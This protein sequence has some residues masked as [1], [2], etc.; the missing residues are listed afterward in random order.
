MEKPWGGRFSEE[1]DKFVEEFTES[2]SFDRELAF[3]DLRQSKAHV[4]TLLRAGVITEEEARRLLDGLDSIERDILEGSFKFSTS[5][6]DVHMNIEAELTKRV[7]DVGG[8]LHTGRSRNDQVATDERL[9]L[10][11]VTDEILDLLSQLR[12][13]LIKKAKD[14]LNLTMP[15]YTHLQRAQ[16]IRVAHYFLAYREMFL[17]DSER[18]CDLLRRLDE[19]PLGS[20]SVAGV[21]FELDRFY[22]ADL[23]GFSKLA[24]NS[25]YAT[26]DRDF[27][28]EFLYCCAQ[29]GLH[30][31]RLSEDLIIFS[32]EEFGFVKLPDRLCTGSSLMPQK[33]NPDVL[34]LIRGKTGRLIGNLV[35]LMVVHKGLP[36]AY[37][38][39]LQ[40]D[41]EPLFDSLRALKG[42]LRGMKMVIDGLEIDGERTGSLS[43]GFLLMTDVANY[44]VRKGIPFRQAH[45][46]AGEITAYLTE[47]GKSL[48][49]IAL[50]ELKTFSDRFSDDVFE[51]LSPEKSADSR[52]TFGGTA[53]EELIRRLN[54]A[55]REEGLS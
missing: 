53:K 51:L 43:G 40:E 36:T 29:T 38:R 24:R 7:G 42:S 30:L 31:S 16:P 49:E 1:T 27:I 28:I 48:D 8:K 55:M 5:L 15:S 52:K 46:I 41:K 17:K 20:G 10:R 35:S 25:I 6:E 14:T 54:V 18:F 21:D 32:T 44:L 12:K 50:E 47:K 34:E 13:A 33:K 2:V 3:D 4:K 26:S 45:R 39:D 22:T 19:L 37:N 9:Y 11:R 23:L